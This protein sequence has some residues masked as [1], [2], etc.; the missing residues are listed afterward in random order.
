M[1][2]VLTKFL[3]G[4]V[5]RLIR[6]SATTAAASWWASKQNNAFYL[7]L[8]PI[9]AAS[10]KFLRDRYPNSWWEVLPF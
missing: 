1:K 8:S 2:E 10:A 7:S 4:T 6:V 3:S 9:L 5:G